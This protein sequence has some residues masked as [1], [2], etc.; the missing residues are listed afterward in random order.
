MADEN[1]LLFQKPNEAKPS[2]F[3][4]LL[5]QENSLYH[6]QGKIH[7][8]GKSSVETY[9]DAVSIAAAIAARRTAIENEGFSL[10]RNW[11]F[12]PS[13]FDFSLLQTELELAT[14]TMWQTL[15]AK[16][17]AINAFALGTDHDAMTILPTAHHFESI[18]DAD[19]EILWCPDEWKISECDESF[20]IPYRLILSQKRDDLTKVGYSSY[21]SGF[22][23]AAIGALEKLN[24]QGVFGEQSTRVVL[25]HFNGSAAKW[26]AVQRLNSPELYA[27]WAKW[28]DVLDD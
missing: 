5:R 10:V 2:E 19:D 27:R 7:T 26:G 12:E 11:V 21:K 1:W 28:W 15:R 13:Q 3:A 25:F 24:S 17:P 4:E 20:D 14:K 16:N 18:A 6:R 9:G 22:R 8:W 23:S